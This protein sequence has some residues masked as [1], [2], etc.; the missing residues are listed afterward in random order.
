MIAPLGWML[1]IQDSRKRWI[2]DAAPH[3]S[4]LPVPLVFDHLGRTHAE[5][6]ANGSEFKALCKLLETGR[7]W[8]K[9]SGP[10]YSSVDGHP[11]YADVAERVRILVDARPDRVLWALN[12]PHP[13]LDYDGF[14][15]SADLL[16]PLLDWVPDAAVRKMILADNPGRLY[17]FDA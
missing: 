7:I 2:A 9:I 10:N 13:G 6:G 5:E 3:L 8:V 12:W 1:Q 4:D 15:D 17:G 11:G 14:V 16:D